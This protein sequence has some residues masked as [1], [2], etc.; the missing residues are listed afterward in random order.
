M[1]DEK[2]TFTDEMGKEHPLKKPK[3]GAM[4]VVGFLILSLVMGSLGAVG[5]LVIFSSNTNLK[6]KLGLNNLPINSTSTEKLVLEESSAFTDVAKK[7]SP[8]VVSITTTTNVQNFFGQSLGTET[9]GGTG[10]IIT[11]DGLIATNK[12]V[13]SDT[14]AQYTVFT[15]DGKEY[16]AKLQAT[17]PSNDF[18]VLKIDASGL[19]VVDLG[20]SD[21]LSVGQWVVAIGNALGEFQ[22]TVTVGV[23]S[24]K[25]R[26]ITASGGTTSEQLTGLIQTDAA[27]NPGNSGG[28][29][30]NL[31][32]QVVGIDTAVA[33]NAQGIGFAIPINDAKK[34]IDSIKKTGT[35][36][37]PMLGVRYIPLTKEIAQANSLSVNDGAWVL[38]GKSLSD[39]AVIPGSPADKAGIL[40]N[41]IITAVNGVKITSDNPLN[42]LVSNYNVGDNI[43]LTYLR[44]GKEAKVK[45]TLTASAGTTSN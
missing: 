20:D 27:I 10:F 25:N 5:T 1:K 11:S 38:R 13:A 16:K 4:F 33:G 3:K 14:N 44:K 32:G 12:H 26:T 23:V 9:G 29:L 2:I 15:S 19:P 22:N 30:V 31:K 39:V 8:S 35:I 41:D 34:A 36:T 42:K 17:D 6:N 24:A 43:E 45:V 40:E 21:S 7:V 18:A 28:P 37:R